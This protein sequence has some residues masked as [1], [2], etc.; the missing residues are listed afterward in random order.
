MQWLGRYTR[1]VCNFLCSVS[2]QWAKIWNG[3]PVLKL[4]YSSV[5]FGKQRIVHSWG[6]RAGWP[7]RR[8]LNPSW[9]P[10]FILF[11]S[12]PMSLP[13]ANWASQERGVFVSSEFLIL[14]CRVSFAPFS[15]AFSVLCLSSPP[16]WTSFSY[17]KYLTASCSVPLFFLNN[18]YDECAQNVYR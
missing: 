9:L 5:L 16:F 14:V 13:Y 3:G 7:Q 17:S 8:G 10:L 4:G 12:S 18:K 1:R 2:Q 11:V 6:V 15:W